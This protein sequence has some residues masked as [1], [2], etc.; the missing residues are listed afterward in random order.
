M[1]AFASPIPAAFA[2]LDALQTRAAPRQSTEEQYFRT[3]AEEHE[4]AAAFARQ[5]L[6]ETRLR[7]QQHDLEAKLRLQQQL[8]AS[9]QARTPMRSPYQSRAT[10]DRA[11]PDI[12]FE[13]G[14]EEPEAYGGYAE[15]MHHRGQAAMLERQKRAEEQAILRALFEEQRRTQAEHV[16][17]L[18]R[19]RAEEAKVER[20]RIIRAQ[21][22][23][24]QLAEREQA[25][26][27]LAT[28][29][30]EEEKLKSF[31]EALLSAMNTEKEEG[32]D[33]ERKNAMR[34]NTVPTPAPVQTPAPTR[35]PASAPNF[36]T[37]AP[38]AASPTP[39]V[40]S[41]SSDAS[42]HS[43]AHL[44]DKY[45][46]LCSSF[47][48]PS[49]LAFAPTNNSPASAPTLLFNPINAPI[50]AYEHALTG[51]LTE[52]DAVESFGDDHV[53]DVR[54]GLV[55]RVEAELEGLEERKREMWRRSVGEV[56][57]PVVVES[58]PAPVESVEVPVESAP[59][60]V[61]E[62]TPVPA[63]ATAIDPANPLAWLTARLAQPSESEDS[64]VKA[65][66][67]GLSA[68][69]ASESAA[70]ESK[71]ESVTV[72]ASEP[73]T[74]ES[75][76]PVAVEPSESLAVEQPE[77]AAVEQSE[78][79]T[80]EQSENLTIDEPEDLA[81]ESSELTI[82]PRSTESSPSIAAESQ[83]EAEHEHEVVETTEAEPIAIEVE[84]VTETHTSTE[85]ASSSPAPVSEPEK[86]AEP[87]QLANMT[88]PEQLADIAEPEQLADITEPE[89]D[90][91]T[92]STSTAPES[93]ISE[94]ESEPEILTVPEPTKF[95]Q[96]FPDSDSEV[97]T[98]VDADLVSELADRK[99]TSG[100]DE[101]EML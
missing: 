48:F 75:S 52:L 34:R 5:R 81:L 83:P 42:L 2:G 78:S 21:R 20:E 43:I 8:A 60:P 84:I 38:R 51:L 61:V 40:A 39:S 35:A 74:V 82:T 101:F 73:V 25:R 37:P 10:L 32:A 28:R 70:V 63:L 90:S 6:Q 31:F 71:P 91:H 59:A 12:I 13:F 68:R 26:R 17:E 95:V 50:H 4:R 72:E 41:D 3:L 66:R 22:E 98:D 64:E 77:P 96:V 44:Q 23:R 29:A 58:V 54:R 94:S 24:A 99:S 57:V 86:L 93:V 36:P 19:K 47:T 18:H 69:L 65:V 46:S 7:Q 89:V 45:N 92:T 76:E 55:R 53:R 62:S 100:A 11:L 85:L 56:E 49:T 87:E 16:A 88:E 27:H 1:F 80:A 79:V 97:D 33:L 30:V 14:T 15:R 9:L 67:E